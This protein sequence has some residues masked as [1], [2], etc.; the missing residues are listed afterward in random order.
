MRVIPNNEITDTVEVF[1]AARA[2]EIHEQILKLPGGYDY[3]VGVDG[4]KLT[5]GQ[6]QRIGIARLVLR[7][8]KILLFDEASSALDG[9][10]EGNIRSNLMGLFKDRT[11]IVVAHRLSTIVGA[12]MI[13]CVKGGEIVE[14]GTHKELLASKGAY[15]TMWETQSGET[16]KRCKAGRRQKIKQRLINRI[17]WKCSRGIIA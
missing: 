6:R 9:T 16:D 17:C 10:T 13:L 12:D 5:P 4:K 2:A 11:K 7:D 14:E 1:E 8:A 15:R 3:V